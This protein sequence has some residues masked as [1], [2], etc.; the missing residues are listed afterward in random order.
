MKFFDELKRRNVIKET[1]AYLVVSWVLLQVVSTVLPIF[2]AP[3]WVLKTVIFILALG[4]PFWVFFSWTYQVTSE[5]FKRT[6]ENLEEPSVIVATN[7]R[8]NVIIIITLVIAI[9]ISLVDLKSNHG[10][11]E[12]ADSD[13]AI[14]NSIAVLP[15]LDMSPNKDQEYLSDGIAE[16]ILNRLCKFKELS[17]AAVTSSFSFKNKNEDI[18]TIGKKL[19]VNNILEGSVRKNETDIIITVRL[20]NAENGFTLLSESYTDDL[21]NIVGLQ[22]TI[23]LDIA[24]RIESKLS[25][26]GKQLVQS[27]KIKPMAFESYLKGRSQFLNGPLNMLPGEIFTA[28]KYFEAAIDQD[29]TFAEAHAY[30]ALAYFNL[31]DWAL[32]RIEKSKIASALDSAQFLSKRALLLDSLNSGAHLAM[33]SYYFHQF[34]WI[35]AEKSK[36]KAVE[37]NPGGSEEKFILASFL[38]QF[39]QAEEA[40]RLDK[41]AMRLDPLDVRSKIKFIRDLYRARKYDEGIRMCHMVL[42]EKP[43]S[44][45]AY[46]FLGFFYSAKKQYK[47]AA[48][49]LVKQF[50]L[51]GNKKGAAYFKNSDSRAGFQKMIQDIND[52]TPLELRS[53]MWMSW[54]YAGLEDKDNTLK[55]LDIMVNNRLPQISMVSQPYYDFLRDDPRYLELYEKAGF[56][57]YDE[58]KLKQGV[59]LK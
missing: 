10:N 38:G 7:K 52:S 59:N 23:A 46:Q 43:N 35:A 27:K 40:L 12:K 58:Y 1:L 50:E 30:L 24:E 8:L 5:G 36:R 20:T 6:S 19:N 11:E 39:G 17:V 37:L 18:K 42:T 3:D 57:E 49:A 9:A 25:N 26:T 56:K 21:Q 47:E 45:A 16:D 34:N 28:K 14:N 22:S 13:L 33:G 29:S 54:A 48:Q 55:Y 44:S 15:F 4:L 31:A 32:P 41:E 51:V 2:D 53:P